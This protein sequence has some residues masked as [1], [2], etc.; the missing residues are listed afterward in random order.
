VSRSNYHSFLWHAIFLALAKNF[1]DVDTIIPA[2]MVD[3]GGNS[4]HVGLL[5]AILLGG[6]KFAQLFFSS[7]INNKAYKKGFLLLGINTRVASLTGLAVLFVFSS[8]W[9]DATVIATIFI[10]ITLFSISGAF[11]N[12]SYTDILGKSMLA[13][14][15]KS[16]FSIR[17]VLSSIGV[18][19][20]AFLAGKVLTANDYPINYAALFGIAAFA[21]G[22]ASLG[23]W[24]VRE[25]S[26]S[27]V[28]ISSFKKF[29]AVI[30]QEIRTNKR[31]SFYLLVVNTQG[32]VLS[33]MPFLLLYA[34]EHFDSNNQAVGN[35]L[36]L[37]VT[38]GVIVGSLLFYFARR[39]RYQH[40][41]YV[42]SL[43]ALTIPLYVMLEPG[44]ALFT[45]SFLLG[46]IVYTLHNIS[47]NGVLLEVSNNENR[48]LYTG[49][50]GVG[51]LLPAVFPLLGGWIVQQ[52]GFSL[53]FVLFMSLVALSV[54]FI[55]RLQCKR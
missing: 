45:A 11:A 54:Y 13:E 25:I 51:N 47:I 38:G 26:A 31:F 12:I 14:S 33:L 17:Q 42:T 50:S 15:R 29:M 37:K 55:Y 19:L 5:T 4:L 28:R 27:R 49:L 20:S 46:G 16:F 43:L 30:R 53:F 21:L 41:L 1:M 10:L 2:M 23:F 9:E 18:F 8:Q 6:S 35:F 44:P 32:V 3:S 7:F 34:K 36:L 40:M 24:N 39:V 48:A 52:F 22:L